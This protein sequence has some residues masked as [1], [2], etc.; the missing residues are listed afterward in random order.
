MNSSTNAEMA[1]MHF[2]YRLAYVNVKQVPRIYYVRYPNK[3]I[4]GM[5]TP[6]KLLAI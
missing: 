4:P 3:V 6:I 2:I 5:K 1:Q